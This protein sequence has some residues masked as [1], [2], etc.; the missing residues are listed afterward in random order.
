MDRATSSCGKFWIHL[1]EEFKKQLRS[2]TLRITPGGVLSF[3]IVFE[4]NCSIVEVASLILESHAKLL[5]AEIRVLGLNHLDGLVKFVPSE[6]N[7]A[8]KGVDLRHLKQSLNEVVQ[9][10]D[11]LPVQDLHVQLQTRF[12]LTKVPFIDI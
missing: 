4:N 11:G 10:R 6:V 7:L 2:I 12:G 3:L 1:L 5:C 9:C 8:T